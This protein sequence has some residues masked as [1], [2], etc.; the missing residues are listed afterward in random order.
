[1]E[2]LN[3]NQLQNVSGGFSIDQKIKDTDCFAHCM[4]TMHSPIDK[5]AKCRE[6]C[7]QFDTKDQTK[8]RIR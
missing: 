2:E 7:N 5:D 4:K 3:D 6:K 1:M 8:I